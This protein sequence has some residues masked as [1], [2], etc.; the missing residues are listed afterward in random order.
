[1]TLRTRTS[2]RKIWCNWH[3]LSVPLGKAVTLLC[4][5]KWKRYHFCNKSILSLSLALFLYFFHCFDHMRKALY[6]IEDVGISQKMIHNY[7]V[8]GTSLLPSVGL[9]SSIS[10]M[11]H[12]CKRLS[13]SEWKIQQKRTSLRS[14]F[15]S[16]NAKHVHRC[17]IKRIWHCSHE[18][19]QTTRTLC[20]TRQTSPLQV[21]STHLDDRS[22]AWDWTFDRVQES[23]AVCRVFFGK[24]IKLLV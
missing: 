1:M 14:C 4:F 18:C 20:N 6:I 2:Q 7:Q 22:T 12:N 15:S 5:L 8:R 13:W 17:Q 10:A 24:N 3:M 19:K 9:I 16:Y 11:P 23:A 21:C